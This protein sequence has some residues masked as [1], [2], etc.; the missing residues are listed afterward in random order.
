MNVK[1][2]LVV[3]TLLAPHATVALAEPTHDVTWYKAHPVERK[4]MIARCQNNPGQLD[5]TPNCINAKH[6]ESGAIMSSKSKRMGQIK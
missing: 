2:A 6:A 4:A 1:M 3:G 5:R